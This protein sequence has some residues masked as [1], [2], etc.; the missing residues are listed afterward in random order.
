MHQQHMV[1]RKL[2]RLQ[3]NVDGLRIVDLDRDLLAPAEQVALVQGVLVL[4]RAQVA[5]GHDPHAP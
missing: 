5:A 3:H 4:Q 1:E 2:P